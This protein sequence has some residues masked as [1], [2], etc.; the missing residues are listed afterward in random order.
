ML[1]DQW[2]KKMNA[3]RDRDSVQETPVVTE[4][5]S[6]LLR[7]F[8]DWLRL[9]ETEPMVSENDMPQPV[10]LYQL[11]EALIAQRQELK[12]YTKS[13]RQL[14]ELLQQSIEETVK[15]VDALNRIREEQPDVEQKAIKPVLSDLMELD[16]SLQR[17]FA[18]LSALQK[19]FNVLLRDRIETLVSQYH[20]QMSLWEKL[21]QRRTLRRFAGYVIQQQGNEAGLLL[22]AF[23]GG[24]EI[25]LQRMDSVLKNH[26]IQRLNPVGEPVDPET[27]QVVAVV[28]SETVPPGCVVDVLRF[29][30]LWRGRTF[31]FADV[32]AAVKHQNDF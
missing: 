26:S 25:L 20:H 10:G 18:A 27:M 17:T 12:L 31:R 15:A 1:E 19:R 2:Y 6:R 5:T 21:W 11:Y 7:Q 4:Q 28:E 32:C 24:F 16:E 3:P 22:G 8:T 14:Q 29:G 30:Y 9:M 23:Q 13:G